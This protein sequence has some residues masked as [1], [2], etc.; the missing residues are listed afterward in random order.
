MTASSLIDLLTALWLGFTGACIGSFL[1]VVAYRMPLGMSV[2]WKPSHCPNCKHPIR[3]HDNVPVLGWLWL[4]G[5]CR[6]CSEPISPRYAIVEAI[7]GLAFFGL[8]YVELFSGG[9]NLPGGP[10]TAFTGANGT[11]W[12]P[13]WQIIG[14]YI[15]H[16]TLLCLLMCVVLI[17]FDGAKTPDKLLAL[18]LLLGVGATIWGKGLHPGPQNSFYSSCVGAILGCLLGLLFS[19]MGRGRIEVTNNR[20]KL[21]GTVRRAGSFFAHR[22]NLIAGAA[23]CGAFVGPRAISSVAIISLAISLSGNLASGKRSTR[24][25]KTA[26]SSLWIALLLQLLFWMSLHRWTQELV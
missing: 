16:C 9:A 21:K 17:D 19:W 2:V 12:E 23:I 13:Q 11:V 25:T 3:A 7:M 26:L 24:L 4:R 14:V 8:A 6:D 18:S 1:N 10:I 5:R 20:N 15:Y 22:A